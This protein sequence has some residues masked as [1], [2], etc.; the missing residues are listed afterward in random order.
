MGFPELSAIAEIYYDRNSAA[1]YICS[2]RMIKIQTELWFRTFNLFGISDD[3]KSNV[4]LNIGC[5]TGLAE[6]LISPEKDF[7]IGVDISFYMSKIYSKRH[8]NIDSILIDV[9]ITSKLFRSNSIDFSFSI[10]CIQWVKNINN[11]KSLIYNQERLFANKIPKNKNIIQFFPLSKIQLK[12]ILSVFKKGRNFLIT[13]RKDN[14]TRRRYF[15]LY[16]W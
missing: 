14:N 11:S 5:G 3:L 10:S 16:R 2:S 7:L 9:S 8:K 1:D 6:S 15:I 4:F 12:Q 13:D